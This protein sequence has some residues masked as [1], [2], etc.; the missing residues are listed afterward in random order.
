MIEVEH[1]AGDRWLVTVGGVTRTQH[2]VSVTESDL[3]GL[4]GPAT[5][6]E[7]LL[8]ASFRFLL[9]REPNTSIL[10]EFELPVIGRYFPEFERVIQRCLEADRQ[11]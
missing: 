1:I 10:S 11:R 8:R 2:T 9:D 7:E 5:T 4:G 6:A 3:S